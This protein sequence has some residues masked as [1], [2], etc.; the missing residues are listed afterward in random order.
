[1][2]KVK[3]MDDSEIATELSK[4]T[5][6]VNH[7]QTDENTTVKKKHKENPGKEVA[8]EG[9]KIFN[10]EKSMNQDHQTSNVI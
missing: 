9:S 6:Y 5:T 1:M 4:V 10:D 2:K 3:N 7:K 8:K